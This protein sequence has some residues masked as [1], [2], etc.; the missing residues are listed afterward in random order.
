VTTGKTLNTTGVKD[1]IDS[2]H[3]MAEENTTPALDI[4]DIE[5]E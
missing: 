5:I 4:T 3:A 1:D 2:D